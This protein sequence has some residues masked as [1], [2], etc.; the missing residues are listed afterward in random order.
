MQAETL[1]STIGYRIQKTR[2]EADTKE[3]N[4]HPTKTIPEIST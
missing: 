2:E 3:E 1:Y 4:N